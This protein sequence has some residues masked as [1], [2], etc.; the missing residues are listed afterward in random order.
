MPCFNSCLCLMQVLEIT[1][2]WSRYFLCL[3]WL[4][5]SLTKFNADEHLP[6]VTANT[7][8]ESCDKASWLELGSSWATVVLGVLKGFPLISS[9]GTISHFWQHWGADWGTELFIITLVRPLCWKRSKTNQM[10]SFGDKTQFLTKIS[11]SLE[12]WP[13]CKAMVIHLFSE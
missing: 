8:S 5:H 3:E 11:C 7:C 13:N 6:F 2:I 12:K 1:W 4:G 9:A 10:N